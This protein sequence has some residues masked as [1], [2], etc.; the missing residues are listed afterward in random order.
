VRCTWLGDLCCAAAFSCSVLP[1]V[2]GD[3]QGGSEDVRAG[4]YAPRLAASSTELEPEEGPGRLFTTVWPSND[5][6][7]L[8]TPTRKR[9][10]NTN[11]VAQL[12]SA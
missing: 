2:N 11:H 7:L 12:S 1:L 3:L 9:R 5:L 6:H 8:F 10:R 4:N